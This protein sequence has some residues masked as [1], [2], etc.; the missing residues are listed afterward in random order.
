MGVEDALCC[1]DLGVDGIVV[2]NHG[3]SQFDAAPSAPHVL[4]YIREAVGSEMTL[5]ADGGVRSGLDIARLLACG[6]D[7]VLIGRPF[8]Y[9]AAAAGENGVSHMIFV[10]QEELRQTLAQLG[11]RNLAELEHRRIL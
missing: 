6:A 11:C 9:A 4:P 5:M 7:F 10:L 3:C 8:I 2:S 1:K